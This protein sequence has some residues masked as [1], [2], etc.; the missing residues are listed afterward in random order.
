[1]SPSPQ[2]PFTDVHPHVD[3]ETAFQAMVCTYCSKRSPVQI[4]TGSASRDHR[5]GNVSGEKEEYTVCDQTIRPDES[6]TYAIVTA[7]AER[8]GIDPLEL[9]P[10]YEAVNTEALEAL[11][12][13]DVGT[14]TFP[15]EGYLVTVDAD[16]SVRLEVHS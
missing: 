6:V 3:I 11:Y 5:T 7:V 15:Y 13:A 14:L 2:R 8:S 9:Q 1:M 4:D 16:G 10:L 12:T